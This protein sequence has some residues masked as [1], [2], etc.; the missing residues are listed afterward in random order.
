MA[1]ASE[2]TIEAL[3]EANRSYLERFG[4]I[5]IVCATGKSAA[6]ML[7]L[8]R[9]RMT[10]NGERHSIGAQTGAGGGQEKDVGRQRELMV[11][12]REQG[13]ITRLRLLK[14]AEE[15]GDSATKAGLL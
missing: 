2:E 12:A 9:E 1:G 13:K 5:F 15:L 10:Q 3:A 11:A 8:L 6:E 4:F 14:L 7:T